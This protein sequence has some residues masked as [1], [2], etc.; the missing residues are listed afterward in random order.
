MYRFLAVC[1]AS[2]SLFSGTHVYA[3]NW[4]LADGQAWPGRVL[5][6]DGRN[7]AAQ[8]TRPATRTAQQI[9]R[10]QSLTRYDGKLV[11][12]SGLDRVIMEQN[13]LGE[14]VLNQTA[15]IARQVRTDTNGDLYASG[16]ETPLA[17]NPLPDGFIYKKN[18][19]TGALDPVL[20]FSQGDVQRD[21]WG[22]FEVHQ[23][24]IYLATL[25]S[26]AKIYRVESNIPRLVV[27]VPFSVKAFRLT[28]ESEIWATDGAGNILLV[29]DLQHPEL[30]KVKV[31]GV[32]A[33]VDFQRAR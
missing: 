20:T 10:L 2:W 24:Q 31:R 14:Q 25:N 17:G 19:T 3:D 23:G 26:P 8:L 16:L 33:F 21:W 9:P 6:T 5:W 4:E 13:V 7:V 11:F 1:C 32:P 29:D 27:T 30:Y 15:F 22:A 28:S 18:R 12:C